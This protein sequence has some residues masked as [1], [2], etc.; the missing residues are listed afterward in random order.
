[1]GIGYVLALFAKSQTEKIFGSIL[2]LYHNNYLF[3][4]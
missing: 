3:I 4:L 2:I 1:M